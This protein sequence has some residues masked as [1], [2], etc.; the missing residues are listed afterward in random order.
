MMQASDAALG[1]RLDK[2]IYEAVA[3]ERIVGTVVLVARDGELIYHRAGGFADR[4]AERPIS[5]EGIFRL[6]SLTKPLV[7]VAAMRSIETGD[8]RLTDPVT[9]WL[10][11]SRPR[12]G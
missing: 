8:V 11:E 3:E 12:L 5:E 10:P 9:K 1:A 4:E 7:A 2:V 6:S